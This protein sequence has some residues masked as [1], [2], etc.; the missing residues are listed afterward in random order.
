M[1]KKTKKKA[2]VDDVLFAAMVLGAAR[3]NIDL[4]IL[5]LE[6]RQRPYWRRRALMA[7]G[8]ASS[9]LQMAAQ[10]LA[11]HDMRA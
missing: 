6:R 3:A 2:C 4:A 10:E 8:R 5:A 9:G 1:A 11:V 7:M